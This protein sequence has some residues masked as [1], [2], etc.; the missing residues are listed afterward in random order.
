MVTL[1]ESSTRESRKVGVDVLDEVSSVDDSLFI[2]IDSSIFIFL[3]WI[4][5][6]GIL[7][8][9]TR[10]FIWHHIFLNIYD[11]FICLFPGFWG[12]DHV[13]LLTKKIQTKIMSTAKLLLPLHVFCVVI[14]HCLLYFL[15]CL[16]HQAGNFI[17][18][19]SDNFVKSFETWC[20]SSVEPMITSVF[21]SFKDY[22]SHGGGEVW[23][24]HIDE[25]VPL[26]A[27]NVHPWWWGGNHCR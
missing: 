17:G 5:Q 4:G 16:F 2:C 13:P 10:K 26:L 11:L 20:H 1:R 7:L 6:S 9:E 25:G 15:V 23:T 24:G 3:I 27:P 19:C 12:L 22:Q 8:K 18:F 21:G 14:L